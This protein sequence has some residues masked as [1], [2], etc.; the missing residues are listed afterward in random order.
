[1]NATPEMTLPAALTCINYPWKNEKDPDARLDALTAFFKD[2]PLLTIGIEEIEAYQVSKRVLRQ[3][4][5]KINSETDAIIAALTSAGLM[6]PEIE[7]RYMPFVAALEISP[8]NDGEIPALD[9]LTPVIKSAPEDDDMAAFRHAIL[10]V[11]GTAMM[12]EEFRTLKVSD[13]NLLRRNVRVRAYRCVPERTT[14]IRT[15]DNLPDPLESFRFLVKRAERLGTEYLLPWKKTRYLRPMAIKNLF[16]ALHKFCESAGIRGFLDCFDYEI[17]AL[18]LTYWPQLAAT[19]GPGPD[20]YCCGMFEIDPS[21]D[22]DNRHGWLGYYPVPGTT[23]ARLPKD[24]SLD[25]PG[26]RFATA[27]QVAE[28]RKKM[29]MYGNP[30]ASSKP[31]QPRF[32]T[33]FTHPEKEVTPPPIC[34]A[35][36]PEISPEPLPPPVSP[37]PTQASIDRRQMMM[38]AAELV[39]DTGISVEIALQIVAGVNKKAEQE[40]PRTKAFGVCEQVSEVIAEIPNKIRAVAGFTAPTKKTEI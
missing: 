20:E 25:N 35:Q 17:R 27:E 24:Y 37:V 12:W 19:A 23:T 2:V 11:L 31:K 36:A 21:Y 30:N 3:H 22:F 14:S 39:R 6:T 33:E 34:E 5:G 32:R 28:G 18:S 1:M 15:R 26:N 38:E 9:Y 29:G 13:V 40:T 7:D 10:A 8:L 16:F 4:P